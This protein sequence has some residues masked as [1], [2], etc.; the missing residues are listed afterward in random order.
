[1]AGVKWY[2][3][4]VFHRETVLGKE[5]SAKYV[6]PLVPGALIY[7][8]LFAWKESFAVVGPEHAGLCVSS[9][10]PQFLPDTARVTPEF[11]YL[12]CTR[13]KTIE[14]VNAASAGSAAV[15]RNRFKEEEFL[16]LVMPLPPPAEQQ[17]IVERWRSAQS[18]I[19]A[20]NVRV[21]KVSERIDYDCYGAIGFKIA[22]RKTPPKVFA[23]PWA[24]FGR[25]SV[26][27][28][29]QT[30]TGMD[31]EAGKYPLATLDSFLTLVQYGTSEKAN[32]QGRG[33]PVLRIGN[34]KDR[35]VDMTNLKHVEL[36]PKT[37]ESLT[38][39]DGDMLI[40]RTSGSR[41]LVGTCAVFHGNDQAVFASYL[42]RLRFDTARA[43]PDY[44]CWF[45][46]SALGRQQVDSI[47]RQI[48][49]NNINSE[50]IRTLRV[51]LPPLEVQRKLVERLT[52]ART[53][54]A[55]ERAAASQLRERIAT[56]IEAMILGT[57]AA[58]TAKA[59]R[60]T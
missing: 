45:L 50:E 35:V 12:F 33:V 3:E 21:E 56:E 38:L 29:Q 59:D 60:T 40:I 24:G 1:M 36:P 20:A 49:Q 47:S 26:S 54:I 41:D 34:I 48:M 5:M 28:N 39:K 4:G 13:P 6:T 44:V 30:L 23:A 43:N 51:P 2:A 52:A 27:F 46:N 7:N 8:R 55:R 58:T 11:L 42:I 15:S 31:L 57:S 53:E 18:Q 16:Q 37:A 10:F 19:T 14:R 9:E 17:A 32:A 22:E 25:W